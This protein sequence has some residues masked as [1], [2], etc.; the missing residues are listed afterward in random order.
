MSDAIFGTAGRTASERPLLRSILRGARGRCANCGEGA[1]FSRWLRPVDTCS[2]CSTDYTPQRADDL[3]PYLTIFVVGH[4]VIAGFVAAERV[5]SLSAWQHL[6]IWVPLT[7]IMSLVLMQPFKGGT[8]G[9]QW[10]L[11]M[12]GFGDEEDEDGQVRSADE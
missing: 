4:I 10:S 5:F 7:V 1:L 6:A 9:L 3:P 2:Q 11:R 12:H 8:I